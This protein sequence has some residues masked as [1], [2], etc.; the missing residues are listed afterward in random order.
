MSPLHLIGFPCLLSLGLVMIGALAGLG[1]FLARMARDADWRMPRPTLRPTP[2]IAAQ[3]RRTLER[4]R[5]I[6]ALTP[7]GYTR[8]RRLMDASANAYPYWSGGETFGTSCVWAHDRRYALA[9][10]NEESDTADADTDADARSA[11]GRE[12]RTA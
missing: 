7:A 1:L 12:G 5:D 6:G 8:L 11:N 4:W 2:G 10:W 9:E 3:N